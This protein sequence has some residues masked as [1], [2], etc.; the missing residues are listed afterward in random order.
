MYVKPDIWQG[1]IDEI[2]QIKLWLADNST[3]LIGITA[4]GGFG[5]SALAAY[6]YQ[7]ESANFA[8]KFWSDASRKETFTE[9]ARRV[10]LRL[11]MPN[12]T[13]E[14][15]PE[16]SLVD[17]LVNYLCEKPC[18]L[19]IDNLESLLQEDGQSLNSF[20]DKFV[21]AWLEYGNLSKIIVT[22]RERPKLRLTKTQW[23]PLSGLS[24]QEGGALLRDLGILGTPSELEEFAREAQGHPLLLTLV[25]GFLKDKE[26]TKPHIKYLQDYDLDNTKK[27]ITSKQLGGT[28]RGV[29]VWMHQIL[30][31]SFERLS[32]KLQQLLLNISVYQTS[33]YLDAAINQMPEKEISEEDLRLLVRRSLLQEDRDEDEDKIYKFHPLILTYLRS[34]AG[35]LDEAHQRA[36]DYYS[37]PKSFVKNQAHQYLKL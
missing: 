27:L 30:D 24:P 12:A 19:V 6:I 22:A 31:T 34:K 10:L 11:G 32:D 8:K 4:L 25:A 7:N 1:R 9:F 21:K 2:E 20:Y 3:R 17:A 5:K 14:T 13:I 16:L 15:I 28:H 37:N 36:I 35:N 26:E 29:E 33:F 23:L 18:L